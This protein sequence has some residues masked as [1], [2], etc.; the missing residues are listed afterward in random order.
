MFRKSHDIIESFS[1]VG[2]ENVQL[3]VFTMV[4]TV[5]G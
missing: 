3:G 4:A 2:L 5:P 1:V